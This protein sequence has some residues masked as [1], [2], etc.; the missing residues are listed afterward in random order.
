LKLH[1]TAEFVIV[2]ACLVALED[3]ETIEGRFL[4]DSA[5]WQVELGTTG[6]AQRIPVLA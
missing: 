1:Q 4:P 5:R 3:G 2:G 6:P